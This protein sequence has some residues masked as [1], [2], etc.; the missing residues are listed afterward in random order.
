ME[1]KRFVLR[2]DAAECLESR[3]RSE[4]NSGVT[5]SRAGKIL[6]F[7]RGSMSPDLCRT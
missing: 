2:R 6:L 5:L 3:F 1:K 7:S 4:E